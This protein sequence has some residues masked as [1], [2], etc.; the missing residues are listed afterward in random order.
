MG[1][2]VSTKATKF[3]W[4]EDWQCWNMYRWEAGV[5]QTNKEL[6]VRM[7]PPYSG[8]STSNY[9]KVPDYVQMQKYMSKMKCSN[10][11]GRYSLEGNGSETTYETSYWY[12]S[13]NTSGNVYISRRGGSFG[14]AGRYIGSNSS[15]TYYI[16]AALSLIPP[17]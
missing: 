3:L 1:Y 15:N 9:T 6:Y 11:Y 12:G 17:A 10:E 4:I 5:I 8:T 14:V 2:D 16:G 13:T 7:K